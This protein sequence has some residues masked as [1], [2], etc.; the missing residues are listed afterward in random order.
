MESDTA[1]ENGALKSVLRALGANFFIAVIKTIAA[2]FT[3]SGAM[4]AESVH[5]FADCTNQILLL[6]GIKHAKSPATKEHPIGKGRVMYFNSFIVALLLFFM[7]GVFALYEGYQHLVGHEGVNNPLIAVAVIVAS[8]L[9]EGYAL[10][11]AIA[12]VKSELKGKSFF[13]WFKQTKSSEMLVVVVEDVSALMG[14][15]IALIF[16][17]LTYFTGN[18]VYDAVG[19]M[20]IGIV[21]MVMS[22]FL[23]K[24]LYGLLL[25][26]TAEEEKHNGIRSYIEQ[27]P[28][29]KQ[30]YDFIT[31]QH[32][33]FIT[34]SVQAEMQ[35]TGSEDALIDAINRVESGIKEKFPEVRKIFFEPDRNRE[36]IEYPTEDELASAE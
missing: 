12:H 27:S 5:S 21:M 36:V 28:E 11:G 13:K 3:G 32:G 29:V 34:V 20:L 19:M 35:K 7:G 18:P 33:P 2:V 10:K 23:M 25:G 6:L 1:Q 17:L 22:V 31:A 4:L 15:S 9:L 8:M 14:L 30:I 26:E 24:E 16:L